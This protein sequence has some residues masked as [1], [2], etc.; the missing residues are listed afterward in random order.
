MIKIRE[1]GVE[2]NRRLLYISMYG[3]WPDFIL[4]DK[5]IIYQ[6]SQNNIEVDLVTCNGELTSCDQTISYREAYG[7]S[8]E[9][10]CK[11]CNEKTNIYSGEKNRYYIDKGRKMMEKRPIGE[12]QVDFWNDIGFNGEF[13]QS[14]SN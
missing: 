3:C 5:K 12:A 14:T 11:M 1:K 4:L 10:V 7:L 9:Q 8:K 13:M 6:L 2:V